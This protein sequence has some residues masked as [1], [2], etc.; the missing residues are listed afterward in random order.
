M[1]RVS[2]V[3]AG[4][5]GQGEGGMVGVEGPQHGQAPFQR[6]HEVAVAPGVIAAQVLGDQPP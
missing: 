6:L 3:Q 5:V 2:P 4:D 1:A